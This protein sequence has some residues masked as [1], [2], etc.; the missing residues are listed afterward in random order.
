[1]RYTNVKP[2]PRY[3][4][5]LEQSH[6]P[7]DTWERLTPRQAA[8][9]ALILGLRTADGVDR[10]ELDA[11]AAADPPLRRRLAAWRD[12]GL[13]ADDGGRARLTETGFL[14]SDA[15]FVDLL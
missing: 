6:L 1:V 3:V 4:E 12:E 11:R 14:L 2:V 5:R 13:L 10:S 7:V 15:L 8:A 9:E